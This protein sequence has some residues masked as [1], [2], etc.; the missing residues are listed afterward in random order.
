MS[1]AGKVDTS[2][3]DQARR[4]AERA[5]IFATGLPDRIVDDSLVMEFADQ[6]PSGHCALDPI[7]VNE[8]ASASRGVVVVAVHAGI[9]TLNT[10]PDRD[11]L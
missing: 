6:F 9:R 2:C 8:D 5:C 1:R 7:D 11:E 10:R 3:F 4:L